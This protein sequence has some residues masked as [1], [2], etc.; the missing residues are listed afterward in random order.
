MKLSTLILRLREL[1][2]QGYGSKKVVFDADRSADV[3]IRVEHGI[4]G[5]THF[6]QILIKEKD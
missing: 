2:A 4:R 1:E 5:N 6:E 3:E